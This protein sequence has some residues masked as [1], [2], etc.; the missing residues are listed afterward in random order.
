ML[1][2]IIGFRFGWI[3][4]IIIFLLFFRCVVWIWVI[5]VEVSGLCLKWVKICLIFVFSCFSMCLIVSFGGKGGILFC[6]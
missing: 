6:S 4:F 1:E 5:E 3:I 2:W